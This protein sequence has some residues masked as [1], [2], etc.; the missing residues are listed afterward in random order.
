M[1]WNDIF[2]LEWDHVRHGLAGPRFDDEAHGVMVCP[3]HHRGSGWRID[4][5]E[6]RAALRVYLTSKY[7]E[8]WGALRPS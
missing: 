2:R 8:V 4:T 7:P 3:W 6:H 5:K 1:P